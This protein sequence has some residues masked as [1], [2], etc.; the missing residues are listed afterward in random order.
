M[1]QVAILNYAALSGQ[2]RTD[3]EEGFEDGYQLPPIGHCVPPQSRDWDPPLEGASRTVF[4]AVLRKRGP[5]HSPQS[6][7]GQPSGPLIIKSTESCEQ[8]VTIIMPSL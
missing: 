4:T 8:E 6:P 3:P 2:T 1:T 5:T 7:P